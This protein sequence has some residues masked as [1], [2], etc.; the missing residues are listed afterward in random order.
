MEYKVGDWVKVKGEGKVL[1]V[2]GYVVY[3]HGG[4]LLIERGYLSSIWVSP[5]E[6]SL[7]IIPGNVE[8]E[9]RAEFAERMAKKWDE[10]IPIV[11]AQGGD[12]LDA[13][14]MVARYEKEAR[15]WR[16]KLS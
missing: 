6:L 4:R 8:W 2:Y 15:D 10:A 7:A 9:A 11:E 1:W 13:Y 14:A 16:R 3:E 5:Q 12:S